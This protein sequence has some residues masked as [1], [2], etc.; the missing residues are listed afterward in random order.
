MKFCPRL[1]NGD[2]DIKDTYIY[3]AQTACEHSLFVTEQNTMHKQTNKKFWGLL[4]QPSKE[5]KVFTS[6]LSLRIWKG[7]VQYTI[8]VN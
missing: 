1:G 5:L 7:C 8:Y 6:Q 4:F 3:L 2:S